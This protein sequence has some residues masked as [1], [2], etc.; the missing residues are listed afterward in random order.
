MSVRPK[1]RRWLKIAMITFLALLMLP[2]PTVRAHE[3]RPAYLQI[4]EVASGRYHLLW[5]TP[6]L[7]GM[8]L[9]VVLRLPGDVRDVV[10]PAAQE[11]SDSLL[12]R[13]VLDAG[14]LA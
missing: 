8:R 9:P 14:P 10:E 13:R 11:L 5:R 6:V 12:E 3:V 2:L 7:A 1:H 4:D